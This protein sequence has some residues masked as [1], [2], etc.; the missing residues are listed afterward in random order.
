MT[1]SVTA[2]SIGI[3]VAVS[4]QSG[5]SLSLKSSFKANTK[6]QL[7]VFISRLQ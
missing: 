1:I 6:A 3:G 2:V 4:R 7:E 5:A